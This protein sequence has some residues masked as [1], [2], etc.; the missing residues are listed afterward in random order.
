MVRC[1]NGP[2]LITEPDDYCDNWHAV[3]R[4]FGPSRYLSSA[5]SLLRLSAS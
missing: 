3:S 4:M 2:S 5:L 1:G